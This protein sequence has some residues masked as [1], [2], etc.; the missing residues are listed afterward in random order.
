M[1]RGPQGIAPGAHEQDRAVRG[2]GAH[3]VDD[4]GE[5]FLFEAHPDGELAPRDVV[6]RAIV[7]HL[8]R[9]GVRGVFLDLRHLPRDRAAERFPGLAACCARYGLDLG[10]DRV[11]VRP[12]AHYFVGGVACDGAGRTEV[13]GLYVCG[14]AASTGLHGANRLASNSLL[15]GLVLGA[16]AG[17]TA[18]RERAGLFEGWISHAERA[19]RV[20]P[21]RA[22]VEDLQR[23]LRSR[24][25]REVGIER[26]GPALESAAGAIEQWRRVGATLRLERRDGCELSN[27]LLLGA[28]VTQAALVRR[29][30]R[31]AHWRA[32]HPARDDA[33]GR[34]H[35]TWRRGVAAQFVRVRGV[36]RV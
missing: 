12:A 22:E 30:S 9:A 20:R 7:R 4:R 2:E 29:E 16:Q 21:E 26:D 27:L 34:G 5:R 32:D 35:W 13:P 19:R 25:W 18:A 11:P 31:G 14:E 36:T 17:E 23:S 1:G 3:V 10:C 15:E 33:R 6:A 28:L 8:G 24:M